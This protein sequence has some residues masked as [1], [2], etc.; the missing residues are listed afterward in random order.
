MNGYVCFF[1]SKRIEIRA[2]QEALKE[3]TAL[4]T[5]VQ[6]VKN[7]EEIKQKAIAAFKAPKSKAHMVSVTLAEKDGKQVVHVPTN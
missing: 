4:Q 6:I 3:V 2:E 1:N 5:A 7:R